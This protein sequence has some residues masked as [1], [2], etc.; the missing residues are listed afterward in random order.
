MP[1]EDD[2]CSHLQ[3]GWGRHPETQESKSPFNSLASMSG[4][5]VDAR[6]KTLDQSRGQ[7]QA[8]KVCT[9]VGMLCADLSDIGDHLRKPSKQESGG[10]FPDVLSPKCLGSIRFA[11][12]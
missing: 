1:R 2:S 10:D 11:G 7:V 8:V 5:G 4:G 6:G 3:H 12:G 9:G